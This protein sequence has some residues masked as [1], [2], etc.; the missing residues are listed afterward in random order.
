MINEIKK[1]VNIAK[2][3]IR[4]ELV[5][6]VMTND[7]VA[8][9][10]TRT[11]PGLNIVTTICGTSV[12][13]FR[14]QPCETVKTNSSITITAANNQYVDSSTA[15]QNFRKKGNLDFTFSWTRY[16][17]DFNLLKVPGTIAKAKMYVTATLFWNLEWIIVGESTDLEVD[18]EAAAIVGA[19]QN[20]MMNGFDGGVAGK[21]EK[22]GAVA[23][24]P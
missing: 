1:Q 20:S 6:L 4:V 3:P 5:I 19:T 10:T 7:H 9:T 2:A 16:V 13:Q 15:G 18:I 23:Y 21:I 22:P 17:D 24:W 12:Y 8:N 14:N 11:V